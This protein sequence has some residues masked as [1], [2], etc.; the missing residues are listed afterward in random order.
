[1][2]KADPSLECAEEL[3]CLE[4]LP[5]ERSPDMAEDAAALLLMMSQSVGPAAAE[6]PAAKLEDTG[7]STSSSC[8]EAV[9]PETYLTQQVALSS[10]R[11]GTLPA[12]GICQACR[13]RDKGGIDWGRQVD[14][15]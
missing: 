10:V 11:L 7:G 9:H 1:M 2:E 13:R 8:Y 6:H 3:E 12:W 14:M 15:G 5:F 4:Q